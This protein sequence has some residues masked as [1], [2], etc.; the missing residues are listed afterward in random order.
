MSPRDTSPVEEEGADVDGADLDGA[1]QEG[2]V[3][4]VCRDLNCASLRFTVVASMADMLTNVTATRDLYIKPGHKL[5]ARFDTS[6]GLVPCWN[7]LLELKS[8]SNEIVVFFLNGQADIGPDCC[9]A[10]TIITHNCWPAMLTSLGFTAEE[11]NILSG[12]CDA[13][14]SVPSTAPSPSA[15]APQA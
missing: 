8:C 1:V 7:A 13:A 9:R 2:G 14:A 11:G 5:A 4:S 3:V 12:Y 6:E 15:P 10:I